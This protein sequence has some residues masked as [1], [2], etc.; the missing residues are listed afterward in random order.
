M[1]FMKYCRNKLI[2][3][4][5]VINLWIIIFKNL[6]NLTLFLSPSCSLYPLK[7]ITNFAV[8]DSL[9]LFTM[10]CFIYYR[11]YILQITQP[12]QYRCKQLQ[13]RFAVISKAPSSWDI[14]LRLCS[15]SIL[16]KLDQIIVNLL[17][18][19]VGRFFLAFCVFSCH[20]L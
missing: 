1:I 20:D 13:Y 9:S 3:I 17:V 5:C 15:G 19:F 14:T 16:C 18:Q 7:S 2:F 4:V 11:K 10:E 6:F 12:S 8:M